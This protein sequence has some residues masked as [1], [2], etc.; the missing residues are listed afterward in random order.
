[1]FFI[2][3]YILFF[4]LLYFNYKKKHRSVFS[5]SLIIAYLVSAI[6]GL[7]LYLWFP[8]VNYIE[9]T[10]SYWPLLF[11][12]TV[13]FLWIAPYSRMDNK[14]TSVSLSSKSFNS[15]AIIVGVAYLPVTLLLL[16]NAI[17]V[18]TSVD[19]S[20]YRV[21]EEYYSF[22]VG[23]LFFSLGAWMAGIS[24]VPHVLFFLSFLYKTKTLTKVLLFIASLSFAAVT[25]CFA[26]RDGIVYWIMDSAI[27][28]VLFKDSLPE[29]TKALLKRLFVIVGVF[30]LLILLF[31]TVY[32]FILSYIESESVIE[33]I[34]SY[35][36]QPIHIFSQS[37]N[38]GIEEV[39]KLDKTSYLTY[40]FGTFVKSL[41]S[42]YGM[43]GLFLFTVIHY[44]L[45]NTFVSNYNK[46]HS[47][48]D[49]LIVFTLFQIPLYG[50]FYYRQGLQQLDL[51]YVVF[52]VICILIK[53]M[54]KSK[55]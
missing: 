6:A 51:T 45:V 42:Q 1:M 13:V 21:D 23:G 35:I 50:V 36:G 41:W 25:L 17:N 8:N 53:N 48:Y 47:L 3:V 27:L 37:F 43:L 5:I 55:V 10:R 20:V 31:I 52:I 34:L 2:L 32:R 14:I 11:L 30:V 22:F 40:T 26:G 16:Y 44:I 15:L 54:K 9:D 12:M 4:F 24:Y 38:L 39:R 33:P 46:R 7:V 29:K 18:I 19:I 28:Y 49:F